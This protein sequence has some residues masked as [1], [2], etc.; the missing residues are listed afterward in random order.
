MY[1]VTQD[2]L[3]RL[4]EEIQTEKRTIQTLMDED[5]RMSE[6]DIYKWCRREEELRVTWGYVIALQNRLENLNEFH[7]EADLRLRM[8]VE[9]AA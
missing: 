8:L 7:S 9:R 5:T 1:S 2:Q 4:L 3:T 6:I